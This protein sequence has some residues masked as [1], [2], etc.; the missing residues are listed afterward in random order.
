MWHEET[1]PLRE[2]LV[3]VGM[4]LLSNEL[5]FASTC[6]CYLKARFCVDLLLSSRYSAAKQVHINVEALLRYN[7]VAVEGVPDSEMLRFGFVLI[8]SF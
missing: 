4:V 3:A 1:S 8:L 5:S 6:R 7:R 2:A